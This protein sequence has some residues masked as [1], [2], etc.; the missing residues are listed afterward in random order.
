MFCNRTQKCAQCTIIRQY[1]C[2]RSKLLK[3]AFDIPVFEEPA[4]AVAA[5]D[6]L[7]ADNDLS[8]ADFM[9]VRGSRATCVRALRKLN[10]QQI[11]DLN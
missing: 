3:S 2:L 10:I 4:A 11:D 8:A 1:Y 7:A 9:T 5:D 6:T